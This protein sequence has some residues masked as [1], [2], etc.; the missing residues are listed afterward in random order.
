MAKKI[1]PT[2]VEKK[3]TSPKIFQRDK[4]DFEINIKE[5]DDLTEKQKQILEVALHR[6]TRCIF[7]DGLYGTGK[8]I[9]AV[10][11]SL[12]LLNQKNIFKCQHHLKK[13][14]HHA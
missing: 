1:N 10:L 11:A 4:I 8:T 5:R 6:D 12:K 2:K 13:S 14:I 3:D 7:I 9:L